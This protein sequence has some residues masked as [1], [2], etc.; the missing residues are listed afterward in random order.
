M[1]SR[2]GEQLRSDA[3][4]LPRPVTRPPVNLPDLDDRAIETEA[5]EAASKVRVIRAGRDAWEAI[6][7]A[8]SFESWACRIGPALAIGKRHALKVTRANAAWGRAYSREFNLWV[9]QH[10]FERMPAATR[11]MAVELAENIT[12]IEQWRSTLPEKQRRRLVHPQSIVKRWKASL[13]HGSGRSPQDWKREAVAA[14]ARFCAC[15]K[16]LPPD[17]AAPLWATAQAQ[18]AAVLGA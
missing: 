6:N 1:L 12:A 17:Q 5:K 8:A 2:L 13:A 16:A 11:S 14:W 9:R 4:R 10:G 18:A 7:K 3:N 15:A